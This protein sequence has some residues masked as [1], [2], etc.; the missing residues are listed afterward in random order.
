MPADVVEPAS[1]TSVASADEDESA[2][3][4]SVEE[5]GGELER[6]G[7]ARGAPRRGGGGKKGGWV[8]GR[9][10]GG[11]GTTQRAGTPSAVKTYDRLPRWQLREVV[12]GGAVRMPNGSEGRGR[13]LE[14]ALEGEKGGLARGGPTQPAM[15]HVTATAELDPSRNIVVN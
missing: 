9:R 15:Q 14:R 10:G 1:D 11:E 7:I 2:S 5:E 6:P 8:V 3:E 4:S 12:G 13:Q